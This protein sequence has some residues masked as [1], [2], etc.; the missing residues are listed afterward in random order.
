MDSIYQRAAD[1]ARRDFLTTFATLTGSVLI[2][3]P[4]R[5]RAEQTS[6]GPAD[7]HLIE[8][9]VAANHILAAESVVD[10]YGHVSVRHDKDPNRYLI[11][12]S[13]APAL[14]TAA[15]ILE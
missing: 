14:V 4:A 1:L 6:A 11:A 15:D 3:L 2:G 9:L 7:P 13:I 12:R 10:G 5:S 8:D